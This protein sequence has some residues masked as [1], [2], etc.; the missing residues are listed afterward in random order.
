[1][2]AAGARSSAGGFSPGGVRLLAAILILV[3]LAGCAG[4]GSWL[5]SGETGS[6][7]E[8]VRGLLDRLELAYRTEDLPGFMRWVR[9]RDL[10]ESGSFRTVLEAHFRTV[11]DPRLNLRVDRIREGSSGPVVRLHWVRR[12]RPGS[13]GGAVEQYGEATFLFER[14]GDGLRLVGMRGGNP[15]F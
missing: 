6:T 13:G 12:W 11:R 8:R 1:M 4:G 15:F 7:P 14:A 9:G 3:G 10:L 5:A 2:I